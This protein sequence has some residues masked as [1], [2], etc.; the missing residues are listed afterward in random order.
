[1]IPLWKQPRCSS[2]WEKINKLWYIHVME[3]PSAVKCENEVLIHATIHMWLMLNT[4]RNI[5]ETGLQKA[6]YA[7]I[8]FMH[9][10]AEAKL[11]RNRRQISACRT[12]M[13][14]EG[15]TAN[16]HG[17]ISES[18][19]LFSSWLQWLHNCVHLSKLTEL[20]NHLQVWIFL[21]II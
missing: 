20:Y 17:G 19:A 8:S 21:N 11:Y 15:M 13:W 16:T 9:T 18:D 5:K 12:W 3:Y 1:M 14:E 4:L 6:A 2:T 10:L 7:V